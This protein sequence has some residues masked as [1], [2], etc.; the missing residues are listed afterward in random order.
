MFEGLGLIFHQSSL[1][2]VKFVRVKWLSENK[3]VRV[4]T[5]SI[6]F[7]I[8]AKKSKDSWVYGNDPDLE[9]RLGEA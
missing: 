4:K 9:R 8:L 2:H 3:N 6:S 7:V 5:V 1:L